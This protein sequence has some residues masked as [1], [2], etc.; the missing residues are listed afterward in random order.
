MQ[1][2]FFHVSIR[3]TKYTKVVLFFVLLYEMRNCIQL[4]FSFSFNDSL[5]LFEE[6][7]MYLKLYSL[8]WKSNAKCKALL[9]GH[10]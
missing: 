2:I 7:G 3:L 6:T 10:W 5:L 1:D 4:L 8:K 9:S